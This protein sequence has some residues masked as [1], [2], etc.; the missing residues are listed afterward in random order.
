MLKVLKEP[1]IMK[2]LFLNNIPQTLFKKLTV[3]NFEPNMQLG[4]TWAW[5]ED[6]LIT[7]C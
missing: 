5:K 7:S 6:M 1:S 4:Y 2:S 3:H